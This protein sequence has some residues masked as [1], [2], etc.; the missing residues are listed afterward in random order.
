MLRARLEQL[1]ALYY[2]QVGPLL[3]LFGIGYGRAPALAWTAGVLIVLETLNK[4]YHV[5]RRAST[6]T[7]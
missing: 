5:F 3:V 2:L 4:L 6:Q 1:A 7:G